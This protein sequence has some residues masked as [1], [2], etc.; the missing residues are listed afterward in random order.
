MSMTSDQVIALLEQQAGPKCSGDGLL[1]ALAVQWA[2]EIKHIDSK[3]AHRIA[4]DA[5][6]E[7]QKTEK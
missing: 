5:L 4:K 1:H 2:E 6:N 3:A 7:L